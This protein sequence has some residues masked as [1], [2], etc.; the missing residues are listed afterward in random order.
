MSACRA[1]FL[2]I[3]QTTP[4]LYFTV[5]DIRGSGLRHHRFV[6]PLLLSL[7]ALAAC[8][9]ERSCP[10]CGTVVVAAVG[11]PPS[12]LPPLV[13]ETVGRDIG[14]QVFERLADLQPGGATVDPSA[15]RGRLASE[16]QRVDSVTWRFRLRPG[17]RWHDG[18]PVTAEDVRFSFA[19]FADSALDAPAR[20]YVKD[21]EVT[22][23]D[24]A[25]VRI[26]F[27]RPSAEQLFDAT[28]HV[29][30]FPRHVW[31]PIA[32]AEW[33]ADT[34]TARLVGSG[35]YRVVRWTR[36]ESLVLEA[37][38]TRGD[39]PGIRRLVWRFT[40]DP[41]AALN[42]VLSHEADLLESV[43]SPERVARVERDTAIRAVRYPSAIYGFLGFQARDAVGRPH[44]ILSDRAVRRALAQ[45]VDRERIAQA[46][47]GPD[48]KAP[49]GPISQTL[50][51]WDDRI[52]TLP[53]DSAA[54]ARALDEAGWRRGP[55]GVR[56]KGGRR[57]ELDI[58]V[59]ATSPPR[60]QLAEAVQQAWRGIGAAATITAVDF[61]VFRERLAAGRFDAYI[62]ATLDE[63]SP[64]GLADQWTRAGWGV[65]NFGRYHHPAFDSLLAAAAA[66]P[67]P[68]RGRALWREAL[69]TLNADV[70]AIFLYAPTNVAAVSRRLDGVRINPWSWLSGVVEWRLVEGGR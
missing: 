9:P 11:E 61:P 62:E 30:I 51:I 68:A 67:G 48:T 1:G 41:D 7:F 33:A 13:F 66:E 47:F 39:A 60:R 15:Y 54:A 59:P 45:A 43:G 14:D 16:W 4:G 32:R 5:P 46:V 18:R 58:L 2:Y 8:R 34:S 20:G 35:P 63:P 64:R 55:D 56:A 19:A 28:Y 6:G 26:R 37:D 24:S 42:L 40:A 38:T 36:G 23:E 70:P 3:A 44:P 52:A 25:T 69:D 21:L 57:L 65:L 31:E 17:A 27:P 49:P 29:R 22:V 50:W 10:A 53:H 12:L